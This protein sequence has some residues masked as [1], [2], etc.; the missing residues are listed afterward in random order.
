MKEEE[1]VDGNNNGDEDKA[2]ISP[3]SSLSKMAGTF[4]TVLGAFLVSAAAIVLIADLTESRNV[5][6]I[7]DKLRK[8]EGER[9][10]EDNGNDLYLVTN[11]DSATFTR[12]V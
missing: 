11:V 1:D 6:S 9:E 7:R 3:L 2:D 12:G 8:E 10:R 5:Y 4:C